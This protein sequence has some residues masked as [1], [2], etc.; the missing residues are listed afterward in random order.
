MFLLLPVV[1][2]VGF[3]AVIITAVFALFFGPGLLSAGRWEDD[4][5]NWSRAFQSAP[6]PDVRV[7]HSWYTRSP[8]FT[9]EVRYFFELA[10][11]DRM[12]KTLTF[13]SRPNG[14]REWDEKD[15]GYGNLHFTLNDKPRWFVPKELAA[16]EIY[17]GWD[18]N[19]SYFLLID[20]ATGAIFFTNRI[21]M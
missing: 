8:H 16:Y 6:P 1:L 7:V 19:E 15:Q 18:K 21:G 9:Y 12:R 14:V 17:Q 4:P 11:N 10:P 13:E 3:F 2:V 5:K 20:R